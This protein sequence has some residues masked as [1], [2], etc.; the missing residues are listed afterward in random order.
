MQSLLNRDVKLE[1]NLR[2]ASKLSFE[3]LH[4]G[5]NKQNVNLALAIFHETT[6]AAS[7]AYFP[8]RTDMAGFLS[9]INTWWTIANSKQQYHPNALGNA[10]VNDDGKVEFLLEFAEWLE[11]WSL[12]TGSRVFCLS[13]QTCDALIKTLRFQALLTKELLQ[14]GYAYVLTGRFQSDPIERRFS[15]YRQMN[16]GNFLVSLKEV[17]NSEKI[18][19]CKSLIKQNVIFWNGESNIQRTPDF[20]ELQ[21]FRV[22]AS[23]MSVV[24]QEATLSPDS[25]EVAFVLAGFVAKKLIK[26]MDVKTAKI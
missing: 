20:E 24:M 14:E 25:E 10:I 16:G 5:H 3:A 2:K 22:A 18:L 26:K 21:K 13:K 4:P 15:Q 23:E 19:L 6:I 17:S 12:L 1:A 8:D 9:L 7:K 11:N